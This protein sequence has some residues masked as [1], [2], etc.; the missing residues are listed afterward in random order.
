MVYVDRKQA[1]YPAL[2]SAYVYFAEVLDGPG[3]S[4]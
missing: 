1:T 2:Q 4:K 3:P